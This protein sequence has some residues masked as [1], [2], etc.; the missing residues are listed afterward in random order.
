MKLKMD[1][2]DFVRTSAVVAAGAALAACKPA[3]TAT[4][5]PTA[6]PKATQ[7]PPATQD[8]SSRNLEQI[9]KLSDTKVDVE[10][11]HTRLWVTAEGINTLND[12]MFDKKME[13]LTN[14]HVN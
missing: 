11:Y 12:Q 3:A 13:E 9:K 14:V 5:E 7:A 10:G 4:P 2:R 8:P 6:K 1:R